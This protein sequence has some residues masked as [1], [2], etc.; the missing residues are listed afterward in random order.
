MQIL[1]PSLGGQDR[2]WCNYLPHKNLNFLSLL[3]GCTE[4]QLT[5]IPKLRDSRDCR[6]QVVAV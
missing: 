2:S 1:G 5:K 6:K 4:K 3:L